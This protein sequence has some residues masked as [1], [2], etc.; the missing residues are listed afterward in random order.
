MPDEGFDGLAVIDIEA[1][2]PVWANNLH[3]PNFHSKRYSTYSIQLV[4]DAHPSWNAAAVLAQATKDFET[5]AVAFIV[6][7]LDLCSKPVT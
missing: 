6:A 5:A 2:T 7:T 1:W 4:H 3:A